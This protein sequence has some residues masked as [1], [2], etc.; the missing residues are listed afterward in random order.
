MLFAYDQVIRCFA[1]KDCPS[2][3]EIM[4]LK[5]NDT[6]ANEDNSFLNHIR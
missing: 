2:R 1:N 4:F 6:W 3:H 5:Y